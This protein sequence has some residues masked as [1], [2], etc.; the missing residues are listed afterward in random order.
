MEQH[1]SSIR[2][3]LG[4]PEEVSRRIAN[5]SPSGA[6]GAQ[7]SGEMK[8]E[9]HREIEVFHGFLKVFGWILDGFS[10]PHEASAP[11]CA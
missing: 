7:L 6:E 8:P 11:T 1:A 2:S 4:V 3:I 10:V 5:D 9:N